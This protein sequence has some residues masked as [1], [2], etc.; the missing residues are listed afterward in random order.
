MKLSKIGYLALRDRDLKR[1]VAAVMGKT[2]NTIYRWI[3]IDSDDLTKVAVLETIANETGLTI[4]Q[5][6]DSKVQQL[7][8]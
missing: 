6:L 7:V 1:K 3:K 5:L 2:E 8:A 4:E